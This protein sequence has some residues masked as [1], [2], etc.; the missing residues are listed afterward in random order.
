MPWRPHGRAQVNPDSPEGFGTCDRCGFLYNLNALKFQY[1]WSGTQLIN[2][3]LRVC[4]VT[5]Y[6]K[7]SEFLRTIILPPDPVPLEQPRPEPYAVDESSD[8]VWGGGG[9]WGADGN[10]GDGQQYEP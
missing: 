6:D 9:V 1:Q 7:P 10:W 2:L 8:N 4:T 3:Q 5:C